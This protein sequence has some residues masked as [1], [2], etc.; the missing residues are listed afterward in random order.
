MQAPASH[1]PQD[2][3]NA[4]A[5]ARND[6]A[7]LSGH[8]PAW[9]VL[10]KTPKVPP[11]A[12]DFFDNETLIDLAR[13]DETIKQRFLLREFARTQYIAQEAKEKIIRLSAARSIW[14]SF[15]RSGT[16]SFGLVL[17]ST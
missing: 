2:I 13:T 12:E 14:I 17:H 8:S 6:I 16:R 10:G 11:G 5:G 15:S 3:V 1:S 9:Q 4:V 7:R